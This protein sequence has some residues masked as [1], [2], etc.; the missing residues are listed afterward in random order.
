MA[1]NNLKTDSPI[2][3]RIVRAFLDFLNSV[4]PAPGVDL[5]GIEVARECL[6]DV[7]RLGSSAADEQTKPDSL[8]DIFSSVG[9]DKLKEKLDHGSISVD[10]PSSSLQNDSDS[11]LSRAPMGEAW[12]SKP[13]ASGVSKDELFG[14]F[15]AALEKIHFFRTMPDGSDDPVRI[16]K[17]TQLFHDVLTVLSLSL[18][19]SLFLSLSIEVIFTLSVASILI[20]SAIL[21]Q[22]SLIRKSHVPLQE[23]EKSGCR[24]FNPKNLADTFKSQ[25]N[26]AMQSKQYSD[27]IELYNCAIALSESNAVYYCNRAAAYTQVH[28]YTEAIRDCLKSIEIDP[29]YSK[30]YSRLGLAYYAQGNYRDAIN[31]GFKKGVE[32]DPNY[33]KA[34]SRMGLAYYAQGNYRN[35]INKGFKKAL[36]LDPNNESVKENIL[37]AEQKLREEQQRAE[38]DQNTRSAGQSDPGHHNQSTGGGS[39]SHSAPPPFTSIPFDMSSLPSDFA[40]MFM[41]MASNAN[42]GQH[43]QSGQG[44]DGDNVN[45]GSD[46]P[47]IRIGGNINLNFGEQ[48]PEEL[49]GTLRSLVDMF[50]GGGGASRGNAHN[51]SDG[52]SAPN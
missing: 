44:D 27:A 8:V 2:S 17:A 29:N 7:F 19:L 39:R 26:K 52:R 25:G 51:P 1:A 48:M 20:L 37:V 45:N 33:S 43:S 23:M 5:E 9:T 4:E 31:K 36:Q 18:S 47:G 46:D 32:I 30:A 28:K 16:D 42:Q 41:N 50:S 49:A 21:L 3:R 6:Q 22:A 34:Y 12:T 10:A 40:N 15:F 11:N 38:R 24:D 35:D 14:Q 13:N